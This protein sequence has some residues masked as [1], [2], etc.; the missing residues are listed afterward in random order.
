MAC[1]QVKSDKIVPS[2]VYSSYTASYNEGDRI[3]SFRAQYQVGQGVGG[4][5]VRLAGN[6]RVLLN[7]TQMQEI[8]STLGLIIYQIQIANIS[9]GKL[10]DQYQIDYY[11]NDGKLYSNF[12]SIPGKV[13]ANFPRSINK[14]DGFEI[15]W[16]VA[17]QL[18]ADESV[19]ANL[20]FNNGGSF[21]KDE[22][23][24]ARSGRIRI[25]SDSLVTRTKQ[26]IQAQV[27]RTKKTN[28]VNAPT[29]GGSSVGEYCTGTVSIPMN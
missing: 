1:A 10:N 18:G 15:P 27:C 21:H 11:D 26:N 13:T 17:D 4:T 23:G 7:G 29:V 14:A 8:P 19:Y 25:N 16:T 24:A 22:S 6:S 2:E 28:S 20:S 5:Q 9:P 3:L 12:V